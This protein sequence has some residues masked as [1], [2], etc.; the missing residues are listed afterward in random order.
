MSNRRDRGGRRGEKA[1]GFSFC[2]SK[3]YLFSLRSQR[4]LRFKII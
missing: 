2:A 3:Q 4:S 1:V